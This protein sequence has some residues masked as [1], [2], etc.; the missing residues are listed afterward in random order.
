MIPSPVHAQTFARRLKSLL[1]T[2]TLAALAVGMM[3]SLVQARPNGTWLSKPQIWFHISNNTLDQVMQRIRA[4]RYQY[5]FLDVRNVPDEDQRLV[6]QKIREHQLVPI[7]WVQSPQLRRM[8]IPQLIHEARYA[9]GIQVD[10]HFFTHYSAYHFRQLRAQYNKPIFCSIQPFQRN[11]VPSSGCNQLDVQCYAPQSFQQCVGL[12]DQLRAV[13]SLS[14]DNTLRYQSQL[15]G[16]YYNVFLWPHSHEFHAAAPPAPMVV[17]PLTATT[18]VET[19]QTETV[20]VDTA[21]ADT[22]QAD[23]AQVGTAQTERNPEMKT[24]AN[25]QPLP[26]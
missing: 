25:P 5:V 3:P 23:T 21:Q 15:G 7:V 17:S 8:S 2:G 26:F 12:A 24:A 9:D 19:G 10:D 22:A 14:A 20:Q 6:T 16:R 1:L 4:Q 11:I 18:P 13:T